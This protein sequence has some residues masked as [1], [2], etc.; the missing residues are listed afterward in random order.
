M[1]KTL[2]DVSVALMAV[3]VTGAAQAG[4]IGPHAYVNCYQPGQDR[5]ESFATSNGECWRVEIRCEAGASA[6][7]ALWLDSYTYSETLGFDGQWMLD[8]YFHTDTSNKCSDD[9]DFS[10]AKQIQVKCEFNGGPKVELQAQPADKE[11]CYPKN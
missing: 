11:K 9:G 5:D 4:G 8:S 6:S 10:N 1:K 2:R 7:G 3:G